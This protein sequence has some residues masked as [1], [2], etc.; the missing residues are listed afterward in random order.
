[1]RI[2]EEHIYYITMCPMKSCK[3][4]ISTC[5]NCRFFKRNRQGAVEALPGSPEHEILFCL[6]EVEEDKWL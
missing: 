2:I 3:L 1:M 5:I 6:Y 4:V